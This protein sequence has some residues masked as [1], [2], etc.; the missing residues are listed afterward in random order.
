MG[1]EVGGLA[2]VGRNPLGFLEAFLPESASLFD[3][4]GA[5][6]QVAANMLFTHGMIDAGHHAEVIGPRGARRIARTSRAFRALRPDELARH[7]ALLAQRRARSHVEGIAAELDGALEVARAG[8]VDLLMLRIESLDILT[9]ALFGELLG[10]RQDDGD[11]NLLAVYRYLDE[12][13]AELDAALDAD[14]V[15]VVMSD[16]GIRTAMEHESDAIFV[17]VGSGVPTGRAA[18]SPDLAGVP[19]VLAGW[20]GIETSWPDTAITTSAQARVAR[21]ELP[22]N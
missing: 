17:A 22:P 4:V 2:S 3:R 20:L 8:E 21:S 1:S 7:P 16:H 18:G 19:R 6:D 13:I 14:D 9:H 11:S 15:L 5:G 12:R 10:T